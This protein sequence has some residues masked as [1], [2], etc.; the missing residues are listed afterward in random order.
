MAQIL[1]VISSYDVDAASQMAA[2]L[3]DDYRTWYFDPTLTDSLARSTLRAPELV[4][5]E[6]LPGYAGIEQEARALAAALERELMIEMAPMLG[7]VSMHGWQA[8]NLYYFF[9]GYLWYSRMWDALRER[10]AGHTLQ[11][12]VNDNP[13]N[14]YWPSFVPS[15]L[16]MERLRGWE[17]D[18]QAAHY[19]GRPDETDVIPDLT[20][21]AGRFDVLTHLP[22]CF[23]DAPYFDA[24]IKAAGKRS[25]NIEPKYW[26]V[27]LQPDLQVK[28][29]RVD[30]GQLAAL[31]LVSVVPHGER[32]LQLLHRMLA[33]YIASHEYRARQAVQL[34]KLYQSQL[35]TLQLLERYFGGDRPGKILLSDHDAG[36]HGPLLSYA[37]RHHIPVLQ[38]PHAKVSISSDFS[39]EQ[40][41]ALTH[42]MQGVP[43][44]RGDGM[45]LRRQALAYPEKCSGDSASR[46]MRR[47]GLLLSGISLNGVLSTRPDTYL[48]G[49]ATIADWC[50]RHGIELA[51]R[52]RPGQTLHALILEKAG[53]ALDVQ[54]KGIAGSLAEFVAGVDLCLMYDAPTSAAIECLRNQVPVI[55]PLA[56]PLSPAEILW[57]DARLIPREDIAAALVRLDQFRL[58]EDHFNQFRRRQFADYLSAGAEAHALRRFL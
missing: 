51:I 13:A 32:L 38:L 46:P 42:P 54:E 9:I 12:P 43:M 34:A 30:H 17:I 58:D 53:I 14:F 23:Y 20:G 36:F 25:I 45:A 26:G 29:L 8:L 5:P 10:F 18:F 35:V 1:L 27:P 15:L 39:S 7:E 22:T 52:N 41:T 28:M 2:S 57:S 56:E 16:L 24:E 50:R 19:G 33:P 44:L 37:K 6:D 31:G 47:V 49:I 48:A 4:L 11:L 40:L 3:D 21:K 55:N